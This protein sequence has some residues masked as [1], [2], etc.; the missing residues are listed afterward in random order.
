MRRG[1]SD[2][3]ILDYQLQQRALPPQLAHS[4]ALN[5]GLDY[6]KAASKRLTQALNALISVQGCQ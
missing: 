6:V 4:I 3:P 2:M 5:T 1:A